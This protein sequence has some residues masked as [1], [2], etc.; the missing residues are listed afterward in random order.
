MRV[1]RK[2]FKFMTNV[3]VIIQRTV[4]DHEQ[5][6]VIREGSLNSDS[7]V[8]ATSLA[9]SIQYAQDAVVSKTLI[10]KPSGTITLFAFDRGQELSEHVTPFDALMQVIDGSSQ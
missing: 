5:A 3:I 2:N 9:G 4:Y 10:K 8:A 6:K 1:W 7:M